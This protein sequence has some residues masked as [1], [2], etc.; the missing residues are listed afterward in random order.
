MSKKFL[1]QPLPLSPLLCLLWRHGWLRA[2]YCPHF[3]PKYTP[4]ALCE[5]PR[6]IGIFRARVAGLAPESAAWP[7][8]PLVRNQGD[9]LP[10]EGF[11]HSQRQ[12]IEAR[13]GRSR[14]STPPLFPR[15]PA[16]RRTVFCALS[17]VRA[18]VWTSSPPRVSKRGYMPFLCW[19]PAGVGGGAGFRV[20]AS[21]LSE[22]GGFARGLAERGNGELCT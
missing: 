7:D 1:P 14:T 13:P 4:R 6:P 5:R 22:N 10:P 15:P 21:W 11:S 12:A 19:G 17:I 16:R 9:G 2:L 8:I 3:E 20:R 18:H